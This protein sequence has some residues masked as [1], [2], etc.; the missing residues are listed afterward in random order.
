MDFIR[1]WSTKTELPSKRILSWMGLRASKFYNWRQRYGKANEHNSWIPRDTWLEDWEKKAILDFYKQHPDEG[2]RRLTYTMLDADVVAASPSSVYRILK[3][4]GVLRDVNRKKSKKGKGFKQ[5]SRPHRHWHVD[6][7]SINVCGT[8]FYLCSFLDGFSRYVVH[9]DIRASMTEED[10]EI[11]LQK[12]REKFP[13]VTPRII[14]DN[15]PQFIAKDFIEYI[16]LCGMTHARTSI[17]YPQSN[18]KKERFFR[19]LKSECIRKKTPLSLKNALDVV[20]EYIEHYNDVRLHSAIGYIAPKDMLEGRA[21]SI[22]EAR[23]EKLKKARERRKANRQK[24]R[25]ASLDAF[26]AE[27]PTIIPPGET[28]AGHAEEQPAKG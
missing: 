12:A 3:A 20:A 19:T 25:Q 5:P 4:A 28:E 18:G 16:R 7:T 26:R 2:Y 15:G 14:T 13:G 17:N 1:E 27:S 21:Q 6:I 23:D 8:F 11:I 9:W 10:V 24:A 22:H